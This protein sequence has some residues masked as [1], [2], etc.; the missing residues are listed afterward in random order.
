MKIGDTVKI[1]E[2]TVSSSVNIDRFRGLIGRV[3]S[4]PSPESPNKFVYVR[5]PNEETTCWFPTSLIVIN[6]AESKLLR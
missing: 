4:L 3:T 5:F 6:S 1:N 2:S